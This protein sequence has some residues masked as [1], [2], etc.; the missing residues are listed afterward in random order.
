V[1]TPFPDAAV[2][3]ASVAVKL[4]FEEP[5]G[6]IALALLRASQGSGGPLLVVPDLFYVECVDAI[7]R[8]AR[9]ARSSLGETL[10]RVRGLIAIET[11]VISTRELTVPAVET[12]ETRAISFQDALYVAAAVARQLPLITADDRLVRALSG[13]PCRVLPLRDLAA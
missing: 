6:E 7:R 12:S 3:D 9:R 13:S 5:L 8:Q 2:L 1:S 4:F 10:E 11:E